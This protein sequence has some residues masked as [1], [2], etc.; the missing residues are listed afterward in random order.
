M[1]DVSEPPSSRTDSKCNK[2]PKSYQNIYKV[3]GDF[4]PWKRF[5]AREGISFISVSLCKQK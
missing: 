4:G 1:V 3:V 2:I 5:I